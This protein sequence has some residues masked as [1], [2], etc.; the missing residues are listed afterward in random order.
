MDDKALAKSL[1]GHVAVIH[2]GDDPTRGGRP[3][4]EGDYRRRTGERKRDA[5][6]SDVECPY[7]HGPML[8]SFN[9]ARRVARVLRRVEDDG[10]IVILQTIPKT[11]RV[12]GC[13]TCKTH[14]TLPKRR[15]K[16]EASPSR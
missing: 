12:F 2:P 10:A 4:G 1:R 11:H 6:C 16:R 8:E 15:P 7:C 9:S 3:I 14:F 13:V 5:I